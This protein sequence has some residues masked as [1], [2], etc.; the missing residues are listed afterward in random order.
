MFIK[1]LSINSRLIL[2]S[3]FTTAGISI[4]ALIIFISLLYIER[5]KEIQ[6]ISSQLETTIGKMQLNQKDFIMQS[7]MN[8]VSNFYSNIAVADNYITRLDSYY[9]IIFPNYSKIKE[10]KVA[11]YDFRNCL[12]NLV[13]IQLKIGLDE[14]SG[15][16]GAFREAVERVEKIFEV[17][18]NN[19]LLKDILTL[20]RQEK[21]FMLS[22]SFDYITKWN[23]GFKKIKSD[24]AL[25]PGNSSAMH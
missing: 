14:S 16:Y 6:F 15:L 4:I 11:M 12:D 3:I 7:D 25:Y 20:R 19:I 24:M 5:L 17:Q 10:V 22:K 21:D 9:S 18:S 13:E 1:Q 8:S 23:T 2:I